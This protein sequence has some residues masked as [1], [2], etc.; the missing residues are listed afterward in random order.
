VNWI[1]CSDELPRD[2][3]DVLFVCRR[4]VYG[5]VDGKYGPTG[6][7]GAPDVEYGHHYADTHSWSVAYDMY[8]GDAWQDDEVTHWMRTPEP[9]Q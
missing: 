6:K 2:Q 3:E 1:K 4:R 5:T 9:P 7:Y 8:E